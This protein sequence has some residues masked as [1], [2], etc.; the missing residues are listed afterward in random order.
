MMEAEVRVTLRLGLKKE[1][2]ISQRMQAASKSRKRQG[3]EFLFKT[4]GR[5]IALPPIL[6]F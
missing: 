2:A 6:D 4:S 1:R 5:N 3:N